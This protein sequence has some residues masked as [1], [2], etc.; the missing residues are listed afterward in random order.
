MV[1]VCR[2]VRAGHATWRI[3]DPLLTVYDKDYERACVRTRRAVNALSTTTETV[4]SDMRRDSILQRCAACFGKALAGTSH[5]SDYKQQVGVIDRVRRSQFQFA[6]RAS[7]ARPPPR[8]CGG[9]TA[10][11]RNSS[12]RDR[13]GKRRAWP[14]AVRPGL[15]P[16]R[17]THPGVPIRQCRPPIR[18][19]RPLRRNTAP[20]IPEEQHKEHPCLNFGPCRA[21]G[22]RL[23]VLRKTGRFQV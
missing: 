14:A 20:P 16:I 13:T 21:C 9:R 19:H 18:P 3:G 23:S 2:G 6:D 8:N 1:L 7:P 11:L 12:V 22:R 5:Q 17:Q 4:G 10:V 15:L